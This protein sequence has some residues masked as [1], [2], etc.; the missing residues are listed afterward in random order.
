[1]PPT[2][3]ALVTTSELPKPDRDSGLLV[4]AL[5]QLGVSAAIVPWDQP[6]DW[7]AFRLAV[8]RS[9]WDY[10]RRFQEFSAWAAEAAKATRLLNPLEVVR[11]NAHKQYLLDLPPR[12]VPIVPTMLQRRV[13][14]GPRELVGTEI[15]GDI[16]VVKPA[17]GSGARDAVKGH[18]EGDA[19]AAQIELLL[20]KGD[21]LIQPFVPEIATAGEVSLIYFEGD[22]SHALRKLPAA[23]DYRVQDQ[24]GGTI[25]PHTPTPGEREVAAAALAA[26][27][28]PVTYA[29]VDLVPYQGYPA[30]MELELIEPELFLRLS[31]PGLQ[32]FAGCLKAAL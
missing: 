28:A 6:A 23:G 20:T 14:G 5:R 22:F 10:P 15:P 30:I 31:E 1:M 24:H 26:A 27:P 11:W 19:V 4:E 7:S 17:I 12:G 2:E 29:R 8:L 13:S 21:V 18:R 16:V 3:I 9:P 25:H 32:R